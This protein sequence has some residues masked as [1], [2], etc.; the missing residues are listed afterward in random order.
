MSTALKG[1]FALV[2]AMVLFSSGS[3]SVRAGEAIPL[4]GTVKDTVGNVVAGVEILFVRLPSD[5]FAPTAVTHS[6]K[7]GCFK[8]LDLAPAHYRF[9]AMKQGYR[10][11][12]G[13]VDTGVQDSIDMIL[14][15]AVALDADSLPGDAAWALRVPR[16]GMLYDVGAR[17]LSAEDLG[18]PTASRSLDD[19]LRMELEQMFSIGSDV[20]QSTPQET[21]IQPTE[22]RM[23]LASAIGERGNILV[24]G[25]REKLGASVGND[26]LESK[27]SQEGAAVSVDDG[28]A[29]VPDSK[30]PPFRCVEM[31]Q[32]IRF[33]PTSGTRL[34][35]R[36]LS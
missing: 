7:T 20:I 15:P 33:L 3:G 1:A 5:A 12:V 4:A 32:R 2:L 26:L 29:T 27:A 24:E 17:P 25:R 10:T 35:E 19:T 21:E 9:A 11:L 8:V 22:T 6:D 13:Q 34:L 36:S 30:G 16:R 31:V 18:S 23:M 14:R 28:R